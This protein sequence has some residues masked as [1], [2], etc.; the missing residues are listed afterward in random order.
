[1]KFTFPSVGNRPTDDLEW[2]LLSVN[3]LYKI[4]SGSVVGVCL[5]RDIC[6]DGTEGFLTQQ[7][8]STETMQQK[9]MWMEISKYVSKA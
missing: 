1:M 4:L 9:V 3:S 6:A 2:N 7:I 5:M 8:S